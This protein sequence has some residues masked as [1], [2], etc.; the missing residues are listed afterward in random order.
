MHSNPSFTSYIL[1]QRKITTSLEKF[2]FFCYNIATRTNS[3]P[4]N[5]PGFY[6]SEYYAPVA[7]KWG[8]SFVIV[9]ERRVRCG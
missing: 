2:R 5:S 1:Q 8:S 4:E 6:F 7:K 9:N 3:N